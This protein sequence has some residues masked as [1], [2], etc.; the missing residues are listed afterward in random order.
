MIGGQIIQPDMVY[1]MATNNYI[2]W[3]GSGFDMLEQNTTKQ[4]TGIS[5]RDAVIDYIKKHPKLPECFDGE[6]EGCTRG[7]AISDGRIRPAY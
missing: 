1:E 2:A 6:I 5:M 7:V 4:D 3:G